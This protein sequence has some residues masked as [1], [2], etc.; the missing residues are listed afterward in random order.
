MKNLNFGEYDTYYLQRI[1]WSLEHA[2]DYLRSHDKV[3]WVSI[4]TL[5]QISQKSMEDIK[6]S[7]LLIRVKDPTD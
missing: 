4:P 6:Y 1:L 7:H 3:G 5:L 2:P